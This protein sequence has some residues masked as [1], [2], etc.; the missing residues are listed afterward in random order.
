MPPTQP[1]QRA[2]VAGMARSYRNQE[3]CYVSWERAM[4]ATKP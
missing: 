1:D 3:S 2:A 4:R